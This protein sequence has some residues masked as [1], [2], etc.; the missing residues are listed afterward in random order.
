MHL[1][2]HT[3]CHIQYFQVR[4]IIQHVSSETLSARRTKEDGPVDSLG[5]LF[6]LDGKE[7]FDRRQV[8]EWSHEV[9]C[10]LS[11]Y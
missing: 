5:D 11:D 7:A 1:T 6:I 10:I 2:F 3:S 8:R 9:S 4:V